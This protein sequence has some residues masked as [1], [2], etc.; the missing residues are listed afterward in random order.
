MDPLST[1]TSSSPAPTKQT[2]LHNFEQI[3]S[4]LEGSTT[5]VDRKTKKRIQNR[6]A[7]RTY[8][9]AYHI[10]PQRSR[11][12]LSSLRTGT[13][14]KQRLHDLQ[15]Q[16]HQLQ[17]KEGEQQRDAQ[18]RELEADDSGNEGATFYPPF[19]QIPTTTTMAMPI[20]PN[21]EVTSQDVPGTKPMGPDPW[22]SISS[23]P[24][25]W[26]PPLGGA[27]FV[28]NPFPLPTKPPL[29]LGSGAATLQS[30]SP[31]NLPLDLSNNVLCPQT[32]H[33]E[34]P[35]DTLALSHGVEDTSQ[36][37]IINPVGNIF[38]TDEDGQICHSHGFNSPDLSPWGH[39]P[40]M[41][42]TS[43]DSIPARPIA[44]T[45]QPSYYRD[46]TA[47]MATTPI[48][49]PGSGLPHP[50][51]TVEEQFE[52]VLSCA[53]R[54]G[55]DSFDT[56]ALHYYTRNFHPASALALEQRLSRNRRLPELLAELRKQSVTWSTW[57]RRGYQDEMLKAAEE[58]C[59]VEYNEFHKADGNGSE[60]ES[61]NEASLG[62]MLPNLWGLLT[63][64]VSSN[65]QLSQRQISEVF[66]AVLVT[67]QSLDT[68][69]NPYA[70]VGHTVNGHHASQA[71][72]TPGNAPIRIAKKR[73]EIDLPG[74]VPQ[75]RTP[76]YYR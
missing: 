60:S 22:T 23:Q 35:R 41:R 9:E 42:A 37:Q 8:R 66:T 58:I 11:L 7:Q 72:M 55:F 64:L 45:P 21:L 31:A 34:P 61:M 16:V 76:A 38:N 29:G 28:Y 74:D 47:S 32:C 65:H 44:H 24:N 20:R 12:R 36:R 19:A 75:R 46:A 6:V 26:N 49:W 17:Q 10:T 51:A 69:V 48:Q 57:Q 63:G 68:T 54:V 15:Q 59:T 14:I 71:L 73:S 4:D 67:R 50:Q 39:R 2:A 5:G 62:D 25:M 43:D 70:G 13:R 30:L 27:N 56:M 1:Q 52:Y 33:G 40:E 18:T 53:Q 3:P